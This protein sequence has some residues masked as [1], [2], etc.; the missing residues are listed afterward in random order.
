MEQFI[1]EILN[2]KDGETI[3]E[4]DSLA[5]YA[6]ILLSGKANVFKSFNGK[7][8][9]IV[10]LEEGEI[11]GEMSFFGLAKRGATVIADGKV[12]VGLITKKTFMALLEELPKNARSKL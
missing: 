11:F 4:E 10:T 3:I 7:Q 1:S 2:I 6:Y 9:Y 8:I 5:Y 12:K